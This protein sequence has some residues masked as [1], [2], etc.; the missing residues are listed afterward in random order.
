MMN[1]NVL[2]ESSLTEFE[3]KGLSKKYSFADGHAYQDIPKAFKDTFDQLSSIWQKSIKESHA[4]LEDNFKTKF[5]QLM[6]SNALINHNCFSI[7]PTAS[8]SIDITGAWLSSK[9]YKTGLIEPSFD[10]IYL[11]FKRRGV[12]VFPIPEND[13]LDIVTLRERVRENGL[14]C[15]AL[16]SPNNPTGFKLSKEEFRELSNFCKEE[17]LMLVLDTTFRFFAN[18]VYDE[19]SIILHDNIDFV[20]IEDTG[21]TFPTLDLKVS[22]MVYSNSITREMR[23]LYEEIYLCTSKISLS[24]LSELVTIT[25]RVGWDEIIWND[26]NFRKQKLIEAVEGTGLKIVESSG[27]C[28]LPVV[29]LSTEDTQLTGLELY[30]F[31]EQYDLFVLPGRMF[32]WNSPSANQYFIRMSL[33]T[34]MELLISGLEKFSQALR[35]L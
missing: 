15:L 8:N 21:K 12:D 14:N 35:K 25:H 19:Y 4:T 3:V 9:G 2:Q 13:F 1:K 10:N 30:E 29:W 32:Y 17:N 6:G 5:G 20:V 26:L 7:C 27:R 11:L 28:N 34:A 16:V 23:L 22:L 33:F 18:E 31:L 24:L